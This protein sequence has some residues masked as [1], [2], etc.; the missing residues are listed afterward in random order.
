MVCRDHNGQLLAGMPLPRKKRLGL[1]L[2]HPPRL[3]PYLGPVFDVSKAARRYQ[4][5]SLMR[6]LGESMARAITGFDSLHY[7]VGP[8]LPDL[9]GFLWSGYRIEAAYTFCLEAG[10][11]AEQ[12]LTQTAAMPLRDIAKA[13][14][15][16]LSIDT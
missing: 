15:N 13:G 9:Q 7:R 5:V 2:F 6:N 4:Q 10:T 3:T 14:R 8:T 12:V 16:R 1:M 11:S